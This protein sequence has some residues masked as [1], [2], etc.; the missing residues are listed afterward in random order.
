MEAELVGALVIRS[1]C[2]WIESLYDD[3]RY[4]PI[5]PPGFSVGSENQTPVIQDSTGQIVGR[6]GEEIY[7]G[8]GMGSENAMPECVR[9]QLPADCAGPYWVV[10]D[11]VRLNIRNESTLIELELITTPDRNAILLHQKPTLVEWAEGSAIISGILKLYHPQRCPRIQS[12]SGITDYLP[13]WPAEYSLQITDGVVEIRNGSGGVIAREGEEV[14][15]HGAPVPSSWDSEQ[16][17]QLKRD[18][19]GDCFGPYWIVRP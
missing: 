5:W 17:R 16:F 19:P 15:V 18:I 4:L 13:I 14:L 1:N 10:G 12:E 2:F 11:G 3:K 7:M 6:V 8:G 9:E